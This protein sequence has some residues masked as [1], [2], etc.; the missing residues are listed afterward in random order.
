MNN[1][2][3]VAVIEIGARLFIDNTFV[4]G[5]G[6][7]GIGPACQIALYYAGIVVVCVTLPLFQKA[8]LA[9]HRF[10]LAVAY[11]AWSLMKEHL[12]SYGHLYL[13]MFGA[14]TVC[15]AISFGYDSVQVWEGSTKAPEVEKRGRFTILEAVDRDA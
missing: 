8:Y 10:L 1:A 9:V 14:A 7:G 6:S 13:V 15:C 2:D 3:I 5:L 12:R 11:K 4:N